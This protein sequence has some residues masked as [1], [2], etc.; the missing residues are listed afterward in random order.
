MTDAHKTVL[1]LETS[2]D[3]T[4][5]AIVTT[6][7]KILSNIVLSQVKEHSK[8]MGVVPEVASRAHMNYLEQAIQRALAEAGMS[9]EE[10]DAIAATGGPGLIGGL[11]VGTMYA[12]AI[13]ATTGKPYF[14]IN[15]L[16]GHA[17]TVRLTDGVEFPFLLLLVSGGHCQFVAVHGLGSYKVLGR[18]LDDAAGEAFDKVAKM[19]ELGYPGGPL[20]EAQATQ[21]DPTRYTLP[22]SMGDHA[23]CD[24][25]FSGLKTAVLTLLTRHNSAIDIPDLCASF[26]HTVARI[27]L[28]RLKNAIGIYEGL[29]GVGAKRFVIAG[30]VSANQ[31]IRQVLE[32]HLGSVGYNLFAPPLS[33]CTDNAAMIA[34]CC[35]ERLL[36]GGQPQ[37][38]KF[39]PRSRW[40]MEEV[41]V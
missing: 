16:E 35:C 38:L 19:L 9:L 7:R 14:A 24:M 13:A 30:G 41:G 28:N 11:I 8:Y 34:W 4:A 33:L 39:A 1:A 6:Q 26:Q 20:V 18:T 40:P 29:V 2:C 25:S 32:S 21:G 12:K 23:G 17:L 15:H 36:V 5:A 3:D 31:H 37:N 27:L 22:L 10:V